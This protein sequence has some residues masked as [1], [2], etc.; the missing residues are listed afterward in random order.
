[1]AECKSEV[2]KPFLLPVSSGTGF[3]IGPAYVSPLR[4]KL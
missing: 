2:N 1:M 3:F 4:A